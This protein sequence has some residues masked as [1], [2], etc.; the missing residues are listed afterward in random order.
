[1]TTLLREV[2]A[3]SWSIGNQTGSGL[4]LHSQTTN[5]ESSS[6]F[7][8]S[9]GQLVGCHR[10]L[11]CARLTRYWMGPAF[12]SAASDVPIDTQFLLVEVRKGGPYAIFLPLVDGDFRASLRGSSQ[13]KTNEIICH[14]ESGD[15]SVTTSGTRAVYIGVDEDD[16]YRLIKNSF[17][18]VAMETNHMF[19]VLDDKAIPSHV[20]EF[21]WCTWDAFYSGVTPQGV[22]DGVK[23]LTAAGAPPKTVIL[24]DGWQQVAPQKNIAA[25]NSSDN[26]T[27]VSRLANGLL[28][29]F[30]KLVS[31]LYEKL[32]RKAP[33]NSL[34]NRVWRFLTRTILKSQLWDY[35]DNETDF[36][37]QLRGFDPNEKFQKTLGEKESM[38]LKELIT[39]LKK[40]LGV[41]RFFCWHALNGYWRGVSPDLGSSAGFNATN[42]MP[43]LSEHLLKVEPVLAWDS[44]SLFGV[45]LLTSEQDLAKFYEK[46]HTPLLEAGVDGIKVDVQSGLASLGGGNG[47]GSRIARIYTRALEDSVSKR[48]TSAKGGPS[49]I[50]CMCHSTENL[51]RYQTSSVARASDDF[52]PTRSHSHTVHLVNV[53]YNSLFIGEICLPDWDM[54]TT[55]CEAAELHAAARAVSGGPVYVSDKPGEHDS[56]LLKRLVLED[57]SIL[58]CQRPG[59]PTRD[60]LFSNVGGDATNVLKI[61][62]QNLHGGI[63]GLFNCQGVEWNFRTH[64]NDATNMSPSS[65]TV[66]TKA[67]DVESLR[68]HPGPF[69]AYRYRTRQLYF[70]ENGNTPVDMDL[71]PKQWDIVTYAAIREGVSPRIGRISWAPVGLAE[72]MN[73]GGSILDVSDVMKMS[74]DA[75]PSATI[76][77]RGP[78]QFIAYCRP[79]PLQIS[80]VDDSGAFRSSVSYDYDSPTGALY[81]DLPTERLGKPHLIKVAWE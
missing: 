79:K 74:D 57:G 36:A 53:A 50:N 19:V 28:G 1:M 78:G 38:S 43:Q 3:S 61:W 22:L 32:V 10:L 59:R 60:C 68:N 47:G 71:A 7:D 76:T 4:F 15:E 46:L 45:G 52:Y 12:G 41:S 42:T 5:G 70:L 40:G 44:V 30:A 17:A 75:V 67:H 73:T 13:R 33:H 62:N 21:G 18:E 11:A 9:L 63:V 2:S 72:M 81:F 6:A 25:G 80:I 23:S 55:T 77:S 66:S 37:R 49:C 65:L 20:D 35:F 26:H 29:M 16:P 14:Q 69:V 56:G 39:S 51:Y 34:P 31:V 24:D 54:F 8:T 48:F 27:L 58:R 64:E